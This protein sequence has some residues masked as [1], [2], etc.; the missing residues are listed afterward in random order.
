MPKLIF[1]EKNHHYEFD[2]GRPT[3]S[4]TKFVE[5]YKVGFDREYVSKYKACEKLLP[6]KQF[7]SIKRK[8]KWMTPELLEALSAPLNAKDISRVQKEFKK[9]WRKTNIEATN[10]GTAEHNRKE[11]EAYDKGKLILP[12]TGEEFIVA[13]KVI[14]GYD[15]YS[16]VDNLLDLEPGAYPELLLWHETG[17]VGT[18]D[19]IFISSNPWSGKKTVSV[20]DIKT[21]KK[22][23][24]KS[25]GSKRMKEPIDHLEDCHIVH[26]TLQLSLYAYMLECSGFVVEDLYLDYRPNGDSEI[27]PLVYLREECEKLIANY[28]QKNA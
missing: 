7:R 5:K 21:N 8:Y 2:D 3:I 28:F 16:L 26:Y 22:L 19:M 24:Y 4:V 6:E 15:N 11:K 20:G 9:E 10:K 1:N 17:L 23:D 27:I 13:P 12:L 25:W 18:A 14:K